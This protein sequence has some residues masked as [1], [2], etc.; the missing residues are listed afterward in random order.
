MYWNDDSS[1]YLDETVEIMIFCGTQR[2]LRL[3][4]AEIFYERKKKSIS[5]NQFAFVFLYFLLG[6][7][8]CCF[9]CWPQAAATATTTHS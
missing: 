5:S 2:I 3:S 1:E 6:V 7:G 4:V 8:F 9:G